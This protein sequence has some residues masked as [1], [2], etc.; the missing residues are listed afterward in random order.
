MKLRVTATIAVL[1]TGTS[2]I[3]A[4]LLPLRHGIFVTAEIPCKGASFVDILSYWG[5][6]NGINSQPI[7]CRI[8]KLTR[9]GQAYRLSR[10]CRDIRYGP[11]SY[12][13]L[14][15]VVTDRN[16]FTIN[17]V[18]YRYCGRRAIL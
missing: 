15:V 5:G 17:G 8:T 14:T 4:D 6:Q 2:A 18:R 7:E 16:S 13:Q 10:K 3:A 1:L 12:N 9:S 11:S